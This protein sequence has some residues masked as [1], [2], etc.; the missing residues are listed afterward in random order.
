MKFRDALNFSV[1]MIFVI[2]FAEFFFVL[3]FTKSIILSSTTY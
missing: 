1:E 3:V 2:M